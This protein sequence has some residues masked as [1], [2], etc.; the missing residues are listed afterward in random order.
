MIF[1]I[2]C[3][4]DDNYLQHCMAMLCSVFENNSHT[5]FVHLL[6]HGLSQEAQ[7]KLIDLSTKYHNKILFYNVDVSD[8]SQ[9]EIKHTDLSIATFFRLLLPSVL[10]E[11]IDKI[12]YLDCDVIVLK[13]ITELFSL[14]LDGYGVAAVKDATPGN[15]RHRNIMGLELD[16]RAF[17]AG[18]LMIN[19]DYWRKNNSQKHL[20]SYANEKAK[21]LVMEDQD[22]LNHEFRRH[23]F[24]L[25]YKYGKAPMAIVPLDKNQ[26]WKDIYEYVFDPSIIHYA[27]HV[28][29]WLDI[30]IPDGEYYWKY[31]K[32]AG[33]ENPKITQ[34]SERNRKMIKNTKMR[35]YINFYIRPF[36]PNIFE[37]V[38][39]DVF[40]I[41]VLVSYI[42]RPKAFKIY[43]IK[44]WLAKYNTK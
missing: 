6:H 11:S 17:C 40:D 43:Q 18:V 38:L 27:T 1:H 41:I 8:F 39:R 20:L 28:K 34:A 25:P 12:L 44:R 21:E 15:N 26:K 32:L 5:I 24:M 29:P 9:V 3:S 14:E 37:I 2:T 23:W 7:K 33:F 19:L 42:F 31:V 16:D 22:V 10:D 35:Y 36:I 30:S 4:T 13:D